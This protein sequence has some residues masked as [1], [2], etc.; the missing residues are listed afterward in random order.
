MRVSP[1]EIKVC[2]KHNV[3]YTNLG[4][5]NR[6]RCVECV[7]EY[8]KLPH[9]LEKK[10]E[11]DRNYQA[12]KRLENPDVLKQAQ[13]KY[14]QTDKYRDWKIS[15]LS[16]TCS[17]IYCIRCNNNR[18]YNNDYCVDCNKLLHIINNHD[19][20]SV[21][22]HCNKEYGLDVKISN[23]GKVFQLNKFC[24]VDCN[25]QSKINTQTLYKTT[26]TYKELKRE[27]KRNGT[28]KK[29]VIKK[30]SKY[31]LIYRRILFQRFNYVCQGCNVKCV[32]PNDT[33]YNQDNC[34]TI[35][36]I[37]PISKGGNHTYVNTQLLCRKCNSIKR[38]NEKYFE[39]KQ[40]AKQMELQFDLTMVKHGTGEQLALFE[41]GHGA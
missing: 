17:N 31:Q 7:R 1:N 3:V 4:N 21:C 12:K 29:R 40:R 39:H 22:K 26:D 20:I 25:K 14:K 24:S 19:Y 36:H 15:Q 9:R 33:N 30:G 38:D 23:S 41:Q 34:A 37:K 27:R 35:D 32:H 5:G 10:R 18:V 6:R 16:I 2:E 13:E 28:H 11:I 8:N